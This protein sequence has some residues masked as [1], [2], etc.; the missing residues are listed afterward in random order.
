MVTVVGP[1]TYDE[2]KFSNWFEKGRTLGLDWDLPAKSVSMPRE[3]V[4]KAPGRLYN[5]RSSVKTTRTELQKLLGSLRHV[6]MCIRPAAPF[7]QRVAALARSAPR[8]GDNTNYQ[9]QRDLIARFIRRHEPD[10]HIHMDASD[11]GLCALFPAKKQYLQVRFTED[12][13]A[14]IRHCNETGS[15]VFCIN[16]LE[17]MSAVFSALVWVHKWHSKDAE[18]NKNVRFWID[19]TSAVAWNNRKSSRNSFAQMLLRLLGICEVQHG[20]YSTASHVAGVD[21]DMADAGSRMWES[22]SRAFTFTNLCVGWTCVV[23]WIKHFTYRPPRTISRF[24]GVLLRA[25]SLAQSSRKHYSRAWEQWTAWCGMMRYSPWHTATNVDRNVEQLG[26][27]AVY[28]WK[29]GMNR[30]HQGNT[31]STICAKL[32]AVRWYHKTTADYDP[33]VNA[34]HAIL[35]RGIRRFSDPVVKHQ[36]LSARLLQVIFT[37]LDLTMPRDQ[38]LRGGLL[39]GYF[40]LLRRSEYLF[41]GRR[42]HSYI[43]RLSA[44]RPIDQDD[45]EVLPK[46]AEIVGITLHGSKNTHF[47]REEC[48]F[49]YK[50][51]DKVICPVRGARWIYKGATLFGTRGEDPA[52]S[53]QRGGIT[54][55]DVSAVIKNA[56]KRIGSN[57]PDF[58]PTQ[59]ALAGLQHSSTHVPIDLS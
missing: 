34:S 38:I 59:Y 49:H 55:D 28:F 10:F 31:Y 51:N 36:P 44:I 27:F 16:V 57:L 23:K 39:L 11:Q 3:K 5:L 35:L 7:F 42:V 12:E 50:S 29:Y 20:F 9:T 19:N 22:P 17:L 2:K 25:G 6:V 45:R 41:I 14:L 30:K 47:G 32:C 1:A 52:L 24:F 48:R 18:A 15:N 21:N 37:C 54:S 43:V 26:A 58:Q 56:A 40:F 33:G 13:L 53:M 46:H 4:L 8:H